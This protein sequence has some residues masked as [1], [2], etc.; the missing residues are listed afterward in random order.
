MHTAPAL[1]AVEDDLG[2]VDSEP[3]DALF[4]AMYEMGASDLHLSVGSPPVVRKD[5][6]MQPLV[7]GA[8]PLTPDAILALLLPM[9]PEQTSGSSANGTIPTSP[10]NSTGPRGSAVT[11]S[12]IGE[13]RAPCSASSRRT[14]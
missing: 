9:L 4:R 3:I 14:S 8:P 10:T 1:H 13:G 7:E 5:G 11:R 12:W 2:V 6:R